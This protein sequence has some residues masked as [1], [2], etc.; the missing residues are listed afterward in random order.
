MCQGKKEEED[1]STFKIQRLDDYIKKHG[2][3]LYK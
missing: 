3:R 2:G 1:P